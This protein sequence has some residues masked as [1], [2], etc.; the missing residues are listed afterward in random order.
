MDLEIHCAM[1]GTERIIELRTDD[2]SHGKIDLEKVIA[3]QA[4]GWITSGRRFFLPSAVRLRFD[5][6]TC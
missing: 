2:G 3:K 6:K 4:K 1:C 5:L